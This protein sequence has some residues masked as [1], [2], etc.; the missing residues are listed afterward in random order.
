V[1]RYRFKAEKNLSR[2]FR[3]FS[4]GMKA[5]PNTEDFS[6]V[7]NENAIKQAMKNLLLTQFGE[8]PFQPKTGS[9]V[10]SML[11]ENFDVFMIEGLTDEIRNT[12]KRLEPR[13]AVNDVRCSVDDTNE[14]AVEIDYTIIGEQL[15]YTVDFLL[16]KA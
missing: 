14:L 2:Q 3:D 1:A 4:I 7:K 10:K 16:E 11:F 5:N 15:V 9:R 13:V 12:L 8:R 6:I